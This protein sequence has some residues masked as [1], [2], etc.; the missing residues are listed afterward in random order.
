MYT[1]YFYGGGVESC[2]WEFTSDNAM[3][4]SLLP[5]YQFTCSYQHVVNNY[6][7]YYCYKIIIYNKYIYIKYLYKYYVNISTYTHARTY[8]INTHINYTYM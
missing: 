8:I 3:L 4:C 1:M 2:A 6:Y 5:F 7:Y